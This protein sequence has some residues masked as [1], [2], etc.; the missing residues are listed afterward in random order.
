LLEYPVLPD[1]LPYHR[2]RVRSRPASQVTGAD[3]GI[4]T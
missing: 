3:R 1:M 4:L 2:W